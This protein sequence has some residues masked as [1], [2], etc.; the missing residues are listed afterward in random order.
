MKFRVL[1]FN[2]RNHYPFLVL[3]WS[4]NVIVNS[5]VYLL[6]DNIQKY[7]FY[8][9]SLIKLKNTVVNIKYTIIHII[10]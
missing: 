2:M 8:Y 1:A 7:L 9:D 10:M 3:R 5:P 6:Y 4:S